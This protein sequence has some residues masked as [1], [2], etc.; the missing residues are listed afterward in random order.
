MKRIL[1]LL[2]IIIISMPL[3]AAFAEQ[4]QINQIPGTKLEG[5]KKNLT[6]QDI[7]N[8][9]ASPALSENSPVP[10]QIS[11]QKEPVNKPDINEKKAPEASNASEGDKDSAELSQVEQYI[12]GK[13]ISGVSTNIRQFGYE[14]FGKS[15]SIFTPPVDTPVGPDYVIGPGD[16]IKVAAWGQIEGQWKA[17]VDRDGTLT[18]P[19]IGTLGVTGMSFKELKESLHKEF[20]KY[21]KGFE[22]NVSMGALRTIRIYVVGNAQK[23]GSYTI[24]SLSS[25]VNAIFEAGGP[26]RT[27][28]MRN[29]QLK[30]N[31]NVLTVFDMYDFLLKG[32]KTKDVRL[33]PDDVIF[34]PPVGAVAGVAGRVKVPAIYELK[35]ETRI[36][37]LISMAG[38]VAATGY[39][40]RV[41]AERVFQNE[42]KIIVDTNLKEMDKGKDI[43]LKDLDL[44]KI[45]PISNVIVNAVTVKGNVARPGQ[46][47]W[48]EGMRVSDVIKNTEKDLLPET[49]FEYALIERYLAPDYHKVMMAFNLGKALF[50][51][52]KDEDKFLM[53]YD[54]LIIYSKWDFL[55]RPQVRI[56]GAVNKPGEFELKG[57]MKVSDLIKLAGGTKYFA[58]LEKAELTRV[59]PTPEGPRT[60][61]V[62]V[63]VQKVLEGDAAHDLLLF[64]ND[65]LMIRT[66]PEWQLYRQV[67]IAGEVR[68]PGTY[69]IEKGEKLSSLID[70]A[71]GYTDRAYL[72]GA[73]FVRESVREIQQKSLNEMVMRLERE[74]LAQSTMKASA[75]LSKEEID[76]N[77]LEL[78]GKQKFLESL[79]GLKATGRMV[80]A[81]T[82]LRL[83]K[84]SDFDI[85]LEDGDTLKIPEVNRT[86][87]VTGAVLSPGSFI[88]TDRLNYKDYLAQAGG[89]SKYANADDIYILKADG[90][91]RKTPR[92]FLDWNSKESRWDLEAFKTKTKELEPGDCIIVPEKLEKVAWLRDI[93]DITQILMQIA[94]VA[95]VTVNLF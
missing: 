20:S 44:V 79:K 46:I 60:E 13:S 38:G 11:R 93:K 7:Q 82:H 9:K 36:T 94:V 14:L 32:D 39:L 64:N 27:G 4:V 55:E 15:S 25:L 18:L 77:R 50:E 34:I 65:Y 17:C 16:E 2:V 88:Y 30:R 67:T 70:R 95:G 68:F 24:S 59:K 84:G 33:M 19:K 69:A 78:E 43:L 90:S 91:A 72:R 3:W 86:I 49:Y 89:L 28:S 87:N 10:E 29:I 54:T 51:G 35:G 81:L 12:S 76:A 56:S 26:S 52:R 85:E 74:L 6:P 22:M 1:F 92:S 61:T 42:V 47:Q 21:Y 58:F 57:N 40:Q 5:L 23:P 73:I 83:L 66:V 71:G 41:Q 80:A 8:I 48:F 63:N 62:S 53:P 75:S 37:D 31:G 45:F